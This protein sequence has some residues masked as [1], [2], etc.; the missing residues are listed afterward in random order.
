MTMINYIKKN[1]PHNNYILGPNWAIVIPTVDELEEIRSLTYRK[2]TIKRKCYICG[3]EFDYDQ[4]NHINCRA[5]KI[6]V[7]CKICN[8]IFELDFNK[9]SGTSKALI[10]NTLH[11]HE[12][13]DCFC[14]KECQ[15]KNL[16]NIQEQLKEK[17]KGWYSEQAIKARN[18]PKSQTLRN[19]NAVKNGV[20][21]L[22]KCLEKEQNDA[23]FA[24]IMYSARSNNGKKYGVKNLKAIKSFDIINN[25][26]C[27][28]DKTVNKYVP[29]DEWKRKFMDMNLDFQLPEEFQWVPTFR[30]QNSNDWV[31]TRSAFEHYLTELEIGWFA[32]IKFYVD[33]NG[34]IK[35]L[36]VGKSGSLLVNSSGSDVSFSMDED[37]GPER[38]FL[39]E[40]N[41]AYDWYRTHIAICKCDKEVEAY[42]ME[43]K[44]EEQFHLFQS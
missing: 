17:K 6:V 2:F 11:D 37:D 30:D 29:W 15:N 26:L 43:S 3:V 13:L 16:S 40:S 25:V 8:K 38:R 35:P 12:E 22:Q 23:N 36:V 18:N 4:S 41:G 33:R 42:E 27:Y 9:Y 28:F 7:K 44:I 39:M 5:H 1:Y 14:S 20:N 32:Y 34:E 31:R 10:N 21:G 24:K 19:L